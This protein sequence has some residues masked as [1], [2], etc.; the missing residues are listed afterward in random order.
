LV[1]ARKGIPSTSLPIGADFRMQNDAGATVF[2]LLAGLS[3]LFLRAWLFTCGADKTAN[4]ALTLI[5]ISGESADTL[6][7]DLDTLKLKL[8]GLEKEKRT[9][10]TKLADLGMM[11]AK[12]GALNMELGALK[13]KLITTNTER[14]E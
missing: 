7:S 4:P 14:D 10:S 9:M 8:F 13:K 2:D 12:S 11:K 5:P 3:A 6:E 1:F